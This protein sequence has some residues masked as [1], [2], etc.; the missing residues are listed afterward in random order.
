[1]SYQHGKFVWFEHISADTAKAGKFYSALLGWHIE[2]T[3]MGGPE[4]Y[5]LI[6]NGDQCIG[7]LRPLQAGGSGHWMSY[8]SVA[9]VDASHKAA[10]AAGAKSQMPPTDFG[11]VG[12]GASLLDP[13]G[14][15]FSVW[16][17]TDGDAA[18]AAKTAV[19][20]WH[21]TELMTPDEKKALAF[22]EKVFGYGHDTMDMGPMGTY[23]MWHD[24]EQK[25]NGGM[26]NAA[27]AMK[28]PP[29]WLHYVTV[30]DIDATVERIKNNGGKILNGPMDIPGDDKIA[31]C[32]DPQGGFFAIFAKG[33]NKS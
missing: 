22:Y 26:S 23:F 20:G 24:G 30:D 10:L 3:P 14:A 12:R 15:L 27:T 8:L 13:T 11:P 28:A 16:K 9:D 29:H 21:W 2:A 17:S 5:P 1:M 7:G 32:Q 33:K 18:D 6:M 4:P 19:G 25:T 31:Q